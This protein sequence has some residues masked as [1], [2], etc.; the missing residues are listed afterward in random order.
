MRFLADTHALLW[1]LSGNDLLSIAA[2]NA[3]DDDE[4]DV[5]VSAASA[6]EITIKH[7]LG[8]LPEA[9]AFADDVEGMIRSQ[10]YAAL[11]ITMAHA[12]LAGRLSG[13]HRDPF[14]RMLIAQALLENLT[15]VSNERRFDQFGVRRLW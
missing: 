3:L 4:S 14:D 1:H 5:Y 15:L 13:S 11:P 12:E 6:W 9:E 2:R 10:G 8:K 7:R